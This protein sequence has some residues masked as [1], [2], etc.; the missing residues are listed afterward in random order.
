LLQQERNAT[1]ATKTK[2]QMRDATS[3]KSNKTNEKL[4]V[5]TAKQHYCNNRN[6]KQC[7]MQL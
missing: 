2:K 3:E 4:L 1:T 5:A 7:E 6:K